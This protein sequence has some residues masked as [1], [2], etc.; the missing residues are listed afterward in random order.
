VHAG[1]IAVRIHAG[2]VCGIVYTMMNNIAMDFSFF[3][4]TVRYFPK[5]ESPNESLNV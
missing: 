1:D 5:A 3:H 4:K 2:T